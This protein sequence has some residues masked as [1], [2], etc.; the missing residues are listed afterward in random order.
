MPH[1]KN[2]PKLRYL[3]IWQNDVNAEVGKPWQVTLFCHILVAGSSCSTEPSISRIVEPLGRT[4]IWY[5]DEKFCSCI[6]LFGV[7]NNSRNVVLS[8]SKVDDKKWVWIGV[9]HS[10]C[11]SGQ[12]ACG[13]CMVGCNAHIHAS[14]HSQDQARMTMTT[15]KCEFCTNEKAAIF[16]LLSGRELISLSLSELLS[17]HW[18]QWTS[19]LSSCRWM[20]RDF[21]SHSLV[22]YSLFS[23][24]WCVRIQ[25]RRTSCYYFQHFLGPRRQDIESSSSFFT[26][27]GHRQVV[28]PSIS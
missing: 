17:N 5:Y 9:L 19:M 16:I 26:Q 22:Q 1:R 3:F 18:R 6:V 24:F 8:A 13:S 15:L 27:C 28:H 23:V 2:W 20:E 11:L 14:N 25:S 7:Q 21:R 10:C 12:T 4:E